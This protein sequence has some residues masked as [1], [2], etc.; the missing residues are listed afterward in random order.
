MQRTFFCLFPSSQ[1]HP[2]NL[3]Q[4]I[5]RGNSVQPAVPISTTIKRQGLHITSHPLMST[6]LLH[7]LSDPITHLPQPLHFFPI[8]LS[9]V[10]SFIFLP[11][12]EQFLLL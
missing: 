5:L 1:Y 8:G 3:P 6:Q 7:L 2:T 10:Q 4:R 11:L 9:S 12:S